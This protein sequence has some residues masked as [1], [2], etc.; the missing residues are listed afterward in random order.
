MRIIYFKQSIVQNRKIYDL[1]IH[2]KKVMFFY[3]ELIDEIVS[4]IIIN[5]CTHVTKMCFI[6]N[7]NT[8]KLSVI[9]EI[10]DILSFAR[11]Q[12]LLKLVFVFFI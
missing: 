8:L 1:F 9:I 5:Y 3:L 7:A 2:F 10:F 6:S 11:L 4:D 12:S